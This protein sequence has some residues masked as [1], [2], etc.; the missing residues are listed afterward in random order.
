LL[1]LCWRHAALQGL[2]RP[3]RLAQDRQDALQAQVGRAAPTEGALH[4]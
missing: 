3:V 2:L 1:E 4:T